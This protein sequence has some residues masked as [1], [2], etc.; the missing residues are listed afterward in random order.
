[1]GCI[2]GLLSLS[3]LHHRVLNY[4]QSDVPVVNRQVRG[5][6]HFRIRENAVTAIVMLDRILLIW[7]IRFGFE[8][9]TTAISVQ[10]QSNSRGRLHRVF[11]RKRHQMR[12]LCDFARFL[13]KQALAQSELLSPVTNRHYFE[14]PQFLFSVH[15][16]QLRIF[17]ATTRNAS[18]YLHSL[19]TKRHFLDTHML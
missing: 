11:P 8:T 3:L 1:M 12:H 16:V 5:L 14:S 9:K 4:R 10:R 7:G 13:A 18:H 6:V 2:K 15:P 17:R 19:G